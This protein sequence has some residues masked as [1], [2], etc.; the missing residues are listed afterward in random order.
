MT[1]PHDP[2]LDTLLDLDGQVLVV[3]PDG[4]HWVRFVV[5]RIAVSPEKPHGLDDEFTLHGPEGE[6][7]VGFDNA[8]PVRRQKRGDPQDH[9]HR[10]KT[11]RSY[12]Y[13]DAAT[14]L[15]DFW[16]EV[17]AVLKERGVLP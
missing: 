2:S 3:D 7:L 9:R 1:P 14:L 8:H 13:Q 5:T 6:R 12:E 10:L 11:I 15:A 4:G 17:D 16:T